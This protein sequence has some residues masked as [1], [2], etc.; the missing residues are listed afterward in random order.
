MGGVGVRARF[1]GGDR[2]SAF[3][4]LLIALTTGSGLT[5]SATTNALESKVSKR[6][7]AAG[8]S[9]ITLTC[10]YSAERPD[11]RGGM[12]QIALDHALITFRPRDESRMHVE[13]TFRNIGTSSPNSSRTVYIEFDDVAGK[14]YIRRPLPHVDFHQLA[15]GERKKFDEVLLVPALRPNRYVVRLWIPDP[16]PSKRF[17]P[18]HNLLLSTVGVPDQ[19]TGTNRI[20]AITVEP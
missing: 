11:D 18:T 9:E 3:V 13:L 12:P 1:G 14:N 20:A 5:S 6:C 17:D 4:V 16:K 8:K 7:E 10:D 15:P 2:I 19:P